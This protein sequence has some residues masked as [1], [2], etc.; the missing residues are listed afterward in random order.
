MPNRHP[1]RLTATLVVTAIGLGYA[2]AEVLGDAMHD[3]TIEGLVVETGGDASDDAGRGRDD[4][5]G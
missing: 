1:S 4:G 5:R 3:L 2:V